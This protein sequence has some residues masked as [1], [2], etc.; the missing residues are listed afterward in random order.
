MPSSSTI[1]A[2]AAAVSTSAV[3]SSVLA[4]AEMPAAITLF[5]FTG[6]LNIVIT[7]SPGMPS[8]KVQFEVVTSPV[9]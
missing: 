1:L 6:F 8:I 5:G 2:P 3:T 7:E 4:L 9:V